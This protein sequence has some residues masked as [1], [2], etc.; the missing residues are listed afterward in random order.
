MTVDLLPLLPF[1]GRMT[2][3]GTTMTIMI[4]M[5]AAIERPMHHRFL[6]GY[7]GSA[8]FSIFPDSRVKRMLALNSKKGKGQ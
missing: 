5:R 7:F 2:A 4:T 3:N 6:R 8:S 1:L